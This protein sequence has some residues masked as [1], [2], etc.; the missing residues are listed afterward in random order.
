MRNENNEPKSHNILQLKRK[1]VGSFYDSEKI[2]FFFLD[3][4]KQF[5]STNYLTKQMCKA[6]FLLL[7]H[8]I[9]FKAIGVCVLTFILLYFL[10]P[11]FTLCLSSSFLD[12]WKFCVCAF[13]LLIS[14]V[15]FHS[16]FFRHSVQMIRYI[17]YLDLHSVRRRADAMEN[18]IK[19]CTNTPPE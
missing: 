3:S 17:H 4:P 7:C 1:T 16:I 15:L 13:F 12:L 14:C 10:L 8:S 18:S 9:S 11:F 19:C 2:L 6:T 5:P